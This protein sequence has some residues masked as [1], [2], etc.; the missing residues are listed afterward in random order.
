MTKYIAYYIYSVNAGVSIS[1]IL[2][3]H[4]KIVELID[5]YK[6]KSKDINS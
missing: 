6:E 5:N 2:D 3:P 4:L 1:K